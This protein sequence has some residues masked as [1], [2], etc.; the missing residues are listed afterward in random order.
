MSFNPGK[1]DSKVDRKF[2][3]LLDPGKVR[4]Q[5]LLDLLGISIDGT[6]VT[7]ITIDGTQVRQVTVD[8]DVVFSPA[9]IVDDF[10]DGNL[11]EYTT[12]SGDS[13]GTQS[14]T[15]SFVQNGS[16]GLEIYEDNSQSWAYSTDSNSLNHYPDDDE[17]YRVWVK[18]DGGTDAD[19]KVLVYYGL[20]DRSNAYYAYI[21]SSSVELHTVNSG[22]DNTFA[23]D[24]SPGLSDGTPYDLEIDWSRGGTHTL[25][26]YDNSGTEQV[27]ISGSESVNHQD[28]GIGF[29]ANASG[30]STSTS[31][32]DYAR[33]GGSP[34]GG[35]SV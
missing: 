15:N 5:L 10:E 1:P 30:G 20:T 17:I 35:D 19:P 26:V 9:T 31:Y 14:V 12:G 24:S 13:N 2:V 21:S 29:E 16:N 18:L 3:S 7:D 33:T 22:T 23:S 32:F 11:D 8:G 6:D 27:S 28:S 25:K 4:I 34:A